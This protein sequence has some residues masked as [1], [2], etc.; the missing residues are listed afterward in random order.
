MS[1]DAQVSVPHPINYLPCDLRQVIFLPLC[2]FLICLMLWLTV[3]RSLHVYD[4]KYFISDRWC[5]QLHLS[6]WCLFLQHIEN[7]S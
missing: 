7:Y 3:D 6:S 2:H 1:Q 4:E 5:C